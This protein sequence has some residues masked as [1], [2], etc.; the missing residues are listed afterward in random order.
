MGLSDVVRLMCT[1]PAELCGLSDRK[2]KIAEGYDAGKVFIILH[3]TKFLI[4]LLL[5]PD[6]CV[7]DPDAEFTIT[8][9]IVQ[10]QNKANPYMG[11][12]LKGLVHATIVRGL[13]VFQ[14]G[15]N[16]QQP[17]GELIEKFVAGPK[18]LVKFD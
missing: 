14:D 17:R 15:E 16:F 1:A 4:N 13:Q 3:F 11:R 9:D 18:K 12:K 5:D 8:Q 6:F 7:W 2:G 10:F